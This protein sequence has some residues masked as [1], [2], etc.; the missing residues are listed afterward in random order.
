VKKRI[1]D[2]KKLKQKKRKIEP[3][4][5]SYDP[6]YI[7]TKNI[8]SKEII[9]EM[10]N[11]LE[12][13]NKNDVSEESDQELLNWEINKLKDGIGA[14]CIFYFKL[15]TST[16]KEK[17]EE[18]RKMISKKQTKDI[19]NINDFFKKISLYINLDNITNSLEN[20]IAEIEVKI[21]FK[22]FLV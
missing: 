21:S 13:N 12:N 1:E 22:N 3:N 11:E 15:G 2:I 6:D 9:N 7:E 17:A 19:R 14:H 16:T 18:H 20:D 4:E 10:Y 8:K 5:E